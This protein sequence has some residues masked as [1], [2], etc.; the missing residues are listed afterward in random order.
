MLPMNV[1]ELTVYPHSSSTNQTCHSF[2]HPYCKQLVLSHPI[3]LLNKA[4]VYHKSPK[5]AQFLQHPL[6]RNHK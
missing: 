3:K 1:L 4:N 2:R 6:L 5:V